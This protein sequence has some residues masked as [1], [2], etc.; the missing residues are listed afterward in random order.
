MR[1]DKLTL[2]AQEALVEAEKLASEQS[3]PQIEPE[4]L[5]K[6]LLVQNEGIIPPLLN[7][8][9]ISQGTLFNDV[10]KSLAKLPKVQGQGSRPIS[11]KLNSVLETAFKEADRLK[12][13]YVSTEHLLLALAQTKGM[14][15]QQILSSHGVTAEKILQGPGIDSGRTAGHRPE[16]RRQVPGPGT[17]CQRPDGVGPER[18]A[19]SGHRSR[20]GDPPGGSSAFT[21]H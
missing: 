6:I 7:K 9:G 8:M 2:K 1:Y 11:P 19:G 13:E 12:D 17:L 4:H 20:R 5:F 14:E 3:H 10:E 16:S 21:A 15:S 18:E